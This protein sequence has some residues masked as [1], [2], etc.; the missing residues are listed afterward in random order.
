MSKRINF[1][2]VRLFALSVALLGV[3]AFAQF[4]VSPDH[5]GDSQ[6]RKQTQRRTTAKNQAKPSPTATTVAKKK[7]NAHKKNSA[8]QPQTTAALR[9]R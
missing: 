9:T 8:S 4:E 6:A 7:S 2:F 3:Q 1:R 5:V